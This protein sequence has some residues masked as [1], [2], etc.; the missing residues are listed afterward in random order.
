MPWAG[1]RFHV[2]LQG[3]A[4]RGTDPAFCMTLSA[5]AVCH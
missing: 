4:D 5:H 1:C 3:H 2:P